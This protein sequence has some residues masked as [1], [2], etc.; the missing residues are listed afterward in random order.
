MEGY[1]DTDFLPEREGIDQVVVGGGPLDGRIEGWHEPSDRDKV[2][3]TD[4]QGN[5]LPI[6]SGEGLAVLGRDRL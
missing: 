5:V 6:L 3:L 1:P 4:S 2:N